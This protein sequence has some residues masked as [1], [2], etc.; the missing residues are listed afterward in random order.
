[1][2]DAAVPTTRVVVP[3]P[4]PAGIVLGVAVAVLVI[5]GTEWTDIKRTCARYADRLTLEPR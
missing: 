1:M 5:F 4:V 3:A 2:I